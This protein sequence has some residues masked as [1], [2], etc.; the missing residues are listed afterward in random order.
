MAIS[1]SQNQTVFS[2]DSVG[3]LETEVFAPN[4]TEQQSIP[5]GIKTPVELELDSDDFFVMHRSLVK[6]VRDNFRNLL[7]TNHGE[8]L[9]IGDFGANLG[10]LAF[11]LTSEGGINTALK[12]IKRATSKFMPF[13]ELDTFEP[14]QVKND[15][16]SIAKVAV[17]IT[18]SVPNANIYDQVIEIEVFSVG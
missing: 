6:Q 5:I 8:R 3:E 16:E 10:E 17:R 7:Q 15:D 14:V 12:R 1:T 4:L 2:F 18:Y 13:I 11:E 9:M